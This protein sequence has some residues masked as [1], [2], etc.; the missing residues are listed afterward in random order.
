MPSRAAS[1]PARDTVR[2]VSDPLWT[3]RLALLTST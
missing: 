1:V 2:I 3:C